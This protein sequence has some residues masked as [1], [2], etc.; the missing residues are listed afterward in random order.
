MQTAILLPFLLLAWGCQPP[1]TRAEGDPPTEEAAG[2]LAPSLTVAG[3]TQCHGIAGFLIDEDPA[4]R[5][6]RGGPGEDFDEVG[7]IAP[8]TTSPDEERDWP[9]QFDIVGS[10]NGWLEIERARIADSADVA[11][12]PAVYSGRGWIAAGSVHVSVQSEMGFSE[13]SHASAVLIDGRPT[14]SALEEFGPKRIIA[15][16]DDWILADWAAENDLRSLVYRPE[17]ISQR[18]PLVLRAWV[19]GICDI[20]ETTCDGISGNAPDASP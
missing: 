13:P 2:V 16:S 12:S 3:R 9:Y 14:G 20:I 11:G 5:I 10:Q 15:C 8:P 19:T 1:G 6:V 18:N 7:R 17:A 4:G